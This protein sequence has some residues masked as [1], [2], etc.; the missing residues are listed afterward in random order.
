MQGEG[1]GGHVFCAVLL[2]QRAEGEATQAAAAAAG[3]WEETWSE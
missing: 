1:E 2:A 3:A